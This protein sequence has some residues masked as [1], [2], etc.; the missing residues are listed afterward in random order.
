M[1][2]ALYLIKSG[3]LA[4]YKADD[5]KPLGKV[6]PDGIV[7]GPDGKPLGKLA[8]DGSLVAV[9]TSEG[10]LFVLD[11]HSL[12]ALFKAQPHDL[13]ITNLLLLPA[14]APP[15]RAAITCAGDNSC[16]LTPLPDSALVVRHGGVLLWL[17]LLAVLL[18][19]VYTRPDLL[20]LGPH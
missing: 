12:G 11:G 7:I 4:A 19:L 20:G 9:G 16:I 2:D 13:F 3:E 15:G 6:R 14:E 10:E 18:A 17:S 5:G 1:A 8:A